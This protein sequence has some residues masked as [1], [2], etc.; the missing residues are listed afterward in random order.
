[1]SYVGQ[2][3]TSFTK[4]W[5][6]HRSKWNKLLEGNVKENNINDEQALYRHYLKYHRDHLDE[7]G[8]QICDAFHVTFLSQPNY[9]NLDTEE[10]EWISTI[11]AE[12]NICKTI[13]PK[14][15]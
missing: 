15:R 7:T 3:K 2:T 8:P 1:M 14:Y 5:T 4:R 10:S 13:L 9:E 6:Q 11:K 12:I